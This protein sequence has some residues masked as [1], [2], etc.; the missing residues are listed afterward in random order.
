[1]RWIAKIPEALLTDVAK[2]QIS[3]HA[4]SLVYTTLLSIVPLLALSFSVLKG[5]GVHNQLEPLLLTLLAPLGDMAAQ[6][7]AQLISF[8]SNMKVGVLGAAGLGFLLYTVFSLMRKIVNAINFTWNLNGSRGNAQRFLDY[9]AMLLIVPLLFF[10]LA[11]AA[12]GAVQSAAVKSLLEYEVVSLVYSNI[13]LWL[14]FAMN[15]AALSFIYWFFPGIKV[16]WFAALTGGLIAAGLWKLIGY[17]F[18]MFVVNSTNYTAI[19]S[20]FA[21]IL[22]FMIWL[23]LSWLILLLGSRIA[24]YTQF[25]TAVL[26]GKTEQEPLGSEFAGLEA[27]RMIH[28]SFRDGKGGVL[29]AELISRSQTPETVLRPVLE[30][31]SEN[32]LIVSLGD[33]EQRFLLARDPQSITMAEVIRVLRHGK[34]LQSPPSQHT[35]SITRAIDEAILSKLGNTS[36]AV[37]S[38]DN[39]VNLYPDS[40][41]D[42]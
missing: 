18:S 10:S 41:K 7:S 39:N 26:A 13:L 38:D 37:W 8:V 27:I 40:A 32:Q 11:G 21:T 23:N 4:M 28:N 16:R 22:L 33:R 17:A 9:F 36:L 35:A 25:P 34:A 14:P 29:L 1:M 42:I 12:T 24:Y 3:L 5:F 15:V 6:I 2:G 20:A 30:R 31:F 19:Y